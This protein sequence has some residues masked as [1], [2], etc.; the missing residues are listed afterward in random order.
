MESHLKRKKITVIQGRKRNKRIKK[1]ILEYLL[2]IVHLPLKPISQKCADKVKNTEQLNNENA[3]VSSCIYQL[4]A[5][6]P[7]LLRPKT[8]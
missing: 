7:A 6:M 4:L 8:I 5:M 3:T 2:V 1:V